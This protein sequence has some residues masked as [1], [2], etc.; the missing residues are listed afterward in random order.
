M[1]PAHHVRAGVSDGGQSW[2]LCNLP[3]FKIE[4]KLEYREGMES[5][6]EVVA[7]RATVDNLIP[8][9]LQSEMIIPRA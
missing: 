1:G 5:W 7:Q 4:D 3:Q 2:S 9:A 8:K 6:I